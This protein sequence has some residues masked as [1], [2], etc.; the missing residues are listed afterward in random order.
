MSKEI[1]SFKESQ[2]STGNTG[3]EQTKLSIEAI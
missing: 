2:R 3:E 1:I